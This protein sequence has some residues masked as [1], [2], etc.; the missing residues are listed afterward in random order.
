M[1]VT[2]SAC[3]KIILCG[4][5]AVVYGRPAIALPLPDLRARATASPRPAAHDMHPDDVEIIAPDIGARYW[6]RQQPGRP[7][8]T[9]VTN[10]LAFLGI[11]P[12]DA[13]WRPFNLTVQS[14]IPVSSNLGSGAAVSICAARAT[15]AFFGRPLSA[16]DASA[17]AF[18]VERMHHGTPSGIDNTVIA[19]EQPVWFIRGNAPEI[20]SG[21]AHLPLVIGDTGR[22]VSTRI[23]VGDVRAAW[24]R[25]PTPMEQRFDEIGAIAHAARAALLAGDL[26]GLG[27][28]M[29]AN[30]AALQGLTVSAD[31]LDALCE[32]ARTAGALGAK[33]S[34]GGR[35][36][37]MLALARDA[38]DA[39]TIDAALRAA[40]AARVLRSQG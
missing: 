26:P 4:E 22:S 38:A 8:A 31:S 10:T 40:G 1:N 17:L 39:A 13:N 2:E 20:L 37:A 19:H 33:M 5:H 18:E 21:A 32:A 16:T 7:L 25:D 23:P 29:N 11:T 9:I 36:G 28:L 6:A 14:D 34:G 3:A 12:E 35:G 30:H 27:A 15:A 24:Q